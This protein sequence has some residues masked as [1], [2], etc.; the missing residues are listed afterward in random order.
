LSRKERIADID[1]IMEGDGWLLWTVPELS[2]EKKQLIPH[3][4][5]LL[6]SCP[7]PAV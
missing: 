1:V 2:F 7:R 3:L 5:Q 6:T 4:Q